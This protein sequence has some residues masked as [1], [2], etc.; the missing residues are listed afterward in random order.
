MECCAISC[1]SIGSRRAYWPCTAPGLRLRSTCVTRA[2]AKPSCATIS[3]RW[4]RP[5]GRCR[6]SRLAVFRRNGSSSSSAIMA[7]SRCVIGRSG[8]A[9]TEAPPATSARSRTLC[10]ARHGSAS[11]CAGFVAMRAS[12]SR[13]TPALNT[14]MRWCSPATAIRHSRCSMTRASK[15]VKCSARSV[16]SPMMSSSTPTPAS[17]PAGARSGPPGTTG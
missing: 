10:R 12:T 17:C 11:R 4:P 6:R 9:S 14:S 13:P 15:S 3:R 8:I 16:I 2:T 1:A 7:C 5:S